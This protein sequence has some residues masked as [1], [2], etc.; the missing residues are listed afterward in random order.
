MWR[1]PFY[2]GINVNRMV[3]EPVLGDWEKV[4]SVEDFKKVQD[5][6]LKNPQYKIKKLGHYDGYSSN[7]HVINNHT[8]ISLD[9]KEIDDISYKLIDTWFNQKF[10]HF[11]AGSCFGV[12]THKHRS[13]D[14][15][16][17]Y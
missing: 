16:S 1:N 15:L 12:G 9:I 8:I 4:V 11:R 13:N 14:R 3:D 2:C 6:I 17:L 10:I 5:F 7:N